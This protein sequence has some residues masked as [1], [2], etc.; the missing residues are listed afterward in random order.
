MNTHI[1][2]IANILNLH[3]DNFLDWLQ[4]NVVEWVPFYLHSSEIEEKISMIASASIALQLKKLSDASNLLF[5]PE[6]EREAYATL[7][8]QAEAL[9]T[10]KAVNSEGR[11]GINLS[12]PKV[13]E[14]LNLISETQPQSPLAQLKNQL[15]GFAQR[16]E[17]NWKKAGLIRMPTQEEIDKARQY[18]I[19][20]TWW[21]TLRN[22]ISYKIADEETT[23]EELQQLIAQA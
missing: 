10:G 7:F 9:Y 5:F 17:P 14:L 18:S 20:S 1:K 19:V 22:Q 4:A 13:L 16:V 21:E 23:I 6:Q 15:I 11:P 8:A 2:M 12:N 3:D